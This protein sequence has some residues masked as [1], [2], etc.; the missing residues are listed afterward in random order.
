MLPHSAVFIE[1]F[2]KRS[3]F[4]NLPALTTSVSC[5]VSDIFWTVKIKK[6]W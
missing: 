5:E 4:E 1:K 6:K 2:F 3:F